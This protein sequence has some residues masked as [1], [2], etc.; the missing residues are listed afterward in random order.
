[1]SARRLVVA[2]LVV[3]VIVLVVFRQRLFLRDPIATVERNG[4][5]QQ[6]YRVY[7]NFFNDILLEDLSQNRRVLVQA[8][9]GVPMVP[10]MP[11]HL[12]CLRGMACLTKAEFAPT[13]PLRDR[14]YVPLV[15]MSNASVSFID[16]DGANMRIALR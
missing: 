16:G 12:T 6:D 10:G 3:V 9:N 1:V 11:I 2:G 4:M 13:A 8:R 14:E 7:L 15:E 5:K